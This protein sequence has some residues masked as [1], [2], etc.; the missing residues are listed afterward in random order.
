[1]EDV[2]GLFKKINTIK[3]FGHFSMDVYFNDLDE[4]FVVKLSLIFFKRAYPT[5]HFRNAKLVDSMLDAYNY[6]L[7]I[8]RD[9]P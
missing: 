9:S 6:L 3:A 8:S 7:C 4:T 5:V 1:M 2:E